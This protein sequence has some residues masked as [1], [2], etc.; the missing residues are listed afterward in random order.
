MGEH[1]AVYGRPALVAALGLRCLVEVESTAGDG[2][3]LV[4]PDLG[5][6]EETS[7]ATVRLHADRARE[8]WLEHA[9]DPGARP[10]A[11][12][13]GPDPAHL[14][15][16]ALG[17]TA[18]AARSEP[19][20][21]A[22]VEVR[23]EIPRG[24]GF[25]SSAALAVALPA[26]LL[27][28]W[29][30]TVEP[31]RIERIALEIERRQHGSPSGIDHATALVGGVV[32]AQRTA[33]GAM[34]VEPLAAAALPAFRIF[35]TGEAPDSTGEV[36]ASVGTRFAGRRRELDD[37]LDR[38][39]AATL[40]FAAALARWNDEMRRALAA[41]MHEFED[42]LELLEVV[43]SAVRDV[44][45]MLEASGAAAKISGAGSCRG[46]GAGAL[47]VLPAEREAMEP[48]E[49]TPVRAVLGGPGLAVEPSP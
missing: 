32:R 24:A 29:H 43:P 34:V 15:K 12:V 18:R 5:L 28:A 3:T 35:H 6:E 17:E 16:V 31:A 1:S 45:R 30:E 22:R 40:A 7:W 36:V 25:G 27:A 11:E 9:S 14:V 48:L 49:L 26:A 20:P 4:L 21:G 42:C 19:P 39:E 46:P 2:L 47:L 13:V 33:A 37:L 10:F 23:S 44:I 41:A 38:M 8:L